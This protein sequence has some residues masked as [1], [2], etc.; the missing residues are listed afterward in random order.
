MNNLSPKVTA[1]AAGAA[2]ATIVWTLIA[3]FAPGTFDETAITSLTGAT[4]TL[5]AV[6]FGYFIRDAQRG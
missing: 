1:A 5:L 3:T 4:G 6:V 2:A